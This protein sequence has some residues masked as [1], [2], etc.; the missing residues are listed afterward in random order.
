MIMNPDAALLSMLIVPVIEAGA[1][2]LLMVHPVEPTIVKY[3][4]DSQE[5]IVKKPK[6]TLREKFELMPRLV[7][8]LIPLGLVYFFE[9]FI[10]MGL[11]SDLIIRKLFRNVSL[12]IIINHFLLFFAV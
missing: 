11:V 8:Y 2:W 3:G 4:I 12:K 6:K 9:Y 5:A 7:P 10:N 1:F